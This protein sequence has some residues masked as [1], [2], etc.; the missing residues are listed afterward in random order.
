MW[1]GHLFKM[2]F[3]TLPLEVQVTVSSGLRTNWHSSGRPGRCYRYREG[4]L[5][6]TTKPTAITT[7]FWLGEW[8]KARMHHFDSTMLS[9]QYHCLI[10]MYNVM[11]IHLSYFLHH[12]LCQKWINLEENQLSTKNQSMHLTLFLSILEITYT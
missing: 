9:A 6:Q 1:F 5:Q 4:C 7:P 11:T 10:T 3:G 8:I 2:L 12:F